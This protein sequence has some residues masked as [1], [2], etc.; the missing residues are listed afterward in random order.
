M[1]SNLT[2]ATLIFYIKYKVSIG[3]R[4]S[5]TTI[6]C[7]LMNWLLYIQDSTSLSGNQSS[8]KFL[9]AVQQAK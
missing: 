4:Y 5:S 7:Q 3:Q 2:K 8:W 1:V 9:A 6:V